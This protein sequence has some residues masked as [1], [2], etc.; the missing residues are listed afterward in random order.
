[1]ILCAVI[2]MDLLVGMEFDLFVPS[3]PELLTQFNVSPFLLEALLSVNF[4][5][6][7]LSLF[8][9]GPLA[10]RYG[11]KPI[12]LVGLL[13]FIGGSLLCLHPISYAF[14]LV[15]RFIQGVGIAAPAILSFLI[16]ADSYPLKEQQYLIAMLNGVMNSA[17]AAA[18]V[19][20]SYVTLYFHWEG[21]F[22]VL[23]FLGV[24]VFFM[25]LFFVP[26]HKKSKEILSE[27]GY[28]SVFRSRP[29]MLLMVHIIFMFVP[30]W[31]FIGISP[32][33]YMENLEVSLSHFGYYQGALALVFAFGSIV[34]GF[35][36]TKFDQKKMLS[37]SG[38]VFVFS[39]LSLAFVTFLDIPNALL[40]TFAFLPFVIGQIIPSTIL[41]PVC[42]NFMPHA[43]GRVSAIIQGGR[44]IFSAISLQVVGYCYQG[45]F[46]NVGIVLMGFVSIV[47]IT[48][49][50][51]LKNRNLM[52]VLEE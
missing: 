42:L 51:I 39:F 20:G 17:M 4:A 35:I 43:K 49:F 2:L 37:I 5:G 38:G 15:G 36:I 32:L 21:N 19:V 31:I 22:R 11:R 44:L 16:I 33:L 7:C 3:F 34:L 25:V 29:L 10:D 9:V 24:F 52:R 12:I 50:F 40:I 48:L 1:M 45:S 23:L 28:A 13:A 18:P 30:Y 8:F 14:L 26:A 27:Q 6:Y 41:Y 46:Q 47:G